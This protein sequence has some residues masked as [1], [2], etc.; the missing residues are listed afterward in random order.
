MFNGRK[1]SGNTVH[2]LRKWFASIFIA[3]IVIPH[4]VYAAADLQLV[5]PSGSFG[6]G[7]TFTVDVY[8]RNN[9]QAINA[10]SGALTFPTDMLSVVSLSKS[11]SIIKLWPEEPSY[12]NTNGTVK[13]EG[14]ILNPGYSGVSG[15]VISI[16]FLSKKE[17][18]T[19]VIFASGQV[20]ANDGEG[21]DVVRNLSNG[22]YA[23]VKQNDTPSAI[24]HTPQSSSKP[25][26]SSTT[27]PNQSSWYS[28][29]DVSFS[30][31]VPQGV[32]AVRTLYDTN[33]ASIPTKLYTPPITQKSFKADSD[34]TQYMHVQFKDENGWGEAAHYKF[35]IDTVS[36][37]LLKASLIDSSITTSPKPQV[38]IEAMDDLSGI[39]AID[40]S[41]DGG[42]VTTYEVSTSHLYTL[43]ESAPGKHTALIQAR[44]KAGNIISMPLQYEI[45]AI[46]APKI[47]E[48]TK[49]AQKGDVIKVA[50][51]TY[52]D[53]TVEVVFVNTKTDEMIIGTATS[54]ESGTF[55]YLYTKKMPIGV[56]EMKARVIDQKGAESPFSDAH[57]LNV[58]NQSLIRIGM[59][60][61]NWLSLALLLIMAAL[62]VISTLWYSLLQFSRFRRKVHRTM[63]EAEHALKTNVAALRRD[64]EEFHTVLTKAQKKRE[65]TKEEQTILRKFKKRLEVT[66]KEIEKKLEQ[67]G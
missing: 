4:A 40:I 65:L 63:K 37:S 47:T 33:S 62:L 16:T 41:I 21:T 44:D 46:D 26:I 60:I 42:K 12:S 20:L 15:K 11:G 64:T 51:T 24:E 48:Y 43:P 39:Q 22:E 13:F 19:S 55:E 30:W 18:N 45:T 61:M 28:S 3:A 32:T 31:V 14:V 57:V 17:G 10:I 7:T 53:S 6:K 1:E 9:E 8:V 38:S 56:Y 27:H 35:Q 66:E 52:P 5:P 2:F 23:I 59:F 25:V 29:R 50:G 36:P 58:E 49:F 54:T 34:G 67:I